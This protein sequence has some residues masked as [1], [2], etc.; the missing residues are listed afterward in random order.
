MSAAAPTERRLD[1]GWGEL[2][3]LEAG[4]PNGPQLL[5]LHGWMDN[6]ASFQPLTEQLPE[7]HWVA[8]DYA[9]HGRSDHRPGAQRYYFTDYL[10]D[11]DAAL[12]ALG[13]DRCTLV[14]HSLGT[15]LAACY[16]CADPQRV[17]RV[18]MIDGLGV[19]TE[20]P[21]HAAQRLTKSLY[22]VRH[23]R[24]HRSVFESIELAA[25]ARQLKNPMADHSAR[26]LA[27]R[28]LRPVEDGYRWRTD[29]GAMWDSPYWM[30]EEHSTN[31]LQGI[32]C[33]VLAIVT[34]ILERYLGERQ[35][36]R[37]AAMD[38]ATV[39]ELDGGHHL[40]MDEP[41]RLVDALRAFLFDEDLQHD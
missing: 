5:C 35:P 39:L 16:A 29:P 31:I 30:S 25:R 24:D 12:D 27:E 2:A 33:P 37:L 13:W 32:K 19:I 15:A 18:V 8:L 6:A 4:D 34:P 23:P 41:E 9:G 17:D 36:F 28:A 38:D 7:A 11:L 1:V 3:A 21:R 26:L 10:F 40:H 22:S 14:G 20:D